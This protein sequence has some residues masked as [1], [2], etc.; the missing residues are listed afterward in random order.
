M[1]SG[2][3]K[4]KLV[5]AVRNPFPNQKRTNVITYNKAEDTTIRTLLQQIGFK[6]E[7]I[8][9]LIPIVNGNRTDHDHLLQ[10][11]DDIWITLPIGGG[12]SLPI[13]RG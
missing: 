7:E 4:I 8:L 9:H 5:A 10:D 3:V 1:N 6:E 12:S 2:T 13:N 11:N